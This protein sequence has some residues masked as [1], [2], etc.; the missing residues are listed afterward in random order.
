MPDRLRIDLPALSLF[1]A[2]VEDKSLSRAAERA[3]VVTSAASKRVSELERQLGVVLLH[4][5]GRGVEPT[6]AG[7][8][9]YQHARAI[10]RGVRVAEEAVTD[11]APAGVAKIRLFANRSTLLR[12]VPLAIAR[13]LAQAPEARIDLVERLSFD[14]PRLVI[15]GEADIGVYQAPR[16]APGLTSYPYIR[17]RIV[18]V[19]PNGHP[20]A[21][22]ASLRLEDAIDHDFIGHFP[23]HT[24]EAFMEVA[25]HSVSR[26]PNVR[27]QVTSFEARCTLVRQGVGVA[28]MPEQGARGHAAAMGLTCLPLTDEWAS[29]QY[30]L[31]VRDG[32]ALKTPVAGLVDHLLRAKGDATGPHPEL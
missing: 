12:F 15:D 31:C 10:L 28:L 13:Y 32:A 17:D 30:Y 1:V 25:E 4:R 14:I 19:V 20:L 26:P 9:L 11:F 3:H 6:P 24:F 23:R 27:V 8:M 22:R 2:A 5:H 29:R 21:Q 16:P 18:L 7:A